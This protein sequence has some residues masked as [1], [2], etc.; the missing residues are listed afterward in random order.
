MARLVPLALVL[1][2]AAVGIPLRDLDHVLIDVIAVR[3]VQMPIG[4]IIDVAAVANRLMT[5]R[6]TVLVRAA[7]ACGRADEYAWMASLLIK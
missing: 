6:R 1:W 7:G 5:T 3:M 4:Q 2:R